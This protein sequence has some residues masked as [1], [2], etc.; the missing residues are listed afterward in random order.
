MYEV[1]GE[2]SKAQLADKLATILGDV[3][4]YKFLAHGFHWNVK[5]PDFPQFH[6]FFGELYEDAE[7]SIDPLAENIRKLGFDA[8]HTL[9]DLMTLSC[10]EA[11]QLAGDPIEMARELY[12]ANAHI[13]DCYNHAFEIANALKSQGIADF[14][15]GRIDVHEKWMWQLSATT[16]IDS[17]SIGTAGV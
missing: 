1:S 16:G 2:L 12:L 9:Q 13:V 6:E 5:G 17:M 15:A 3:V 10:I 8:P 7:G 4:T 11:R 14:I